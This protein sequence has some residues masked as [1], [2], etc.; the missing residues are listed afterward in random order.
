[1]AARKDPTIYTGTFHGLKLKAWG[2]DR[3]IPE[4]FAIS[5]YQVHYR[6]EH[7]AA[8]PQLTRQGHQWS[9]PSAESVMAIVKSDFVTCLADFTPAP[10]AKAAGPSLRSA[11]DLPPKQR[12][13]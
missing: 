13:A 12:R 7:W 4:S 3:V 5:I 8:R 9:G 1:M 6:P 2:I 10:A 11:A